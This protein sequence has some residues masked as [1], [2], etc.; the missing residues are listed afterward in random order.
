M[1]KQDI[2][3]TLLYCT[4]KTALIDRIYDDITQFLFKDFITQEINYYY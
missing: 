2:I 1:E 4:N 3:G